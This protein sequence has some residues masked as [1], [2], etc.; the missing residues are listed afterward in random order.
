M[1]VSPA[2]YRPVWIVFFVLETFPEP[3]PKENRSYMIPL[4]PPWNQRSPTGSPP[5]SFKATH[6]VFQSF[7]SF[8]ISAPVFLGLSI[9]GLFLGLLVLKIPLFFIGFV[10]GLDFV[11]IL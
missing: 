10:L 11:L 8:K 2:D 7:Q 6:L 4:P 5:R 9:R 1:W 3:N